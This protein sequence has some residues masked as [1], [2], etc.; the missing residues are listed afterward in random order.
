M[1]WEDWVCCPR[2]DPQSLVQCT[3][4][5]VMGVTPDEHKCAVCETLKH[6]SASLPEPT[7]ET[8]GERGPRG[9]VE[10]LYGR[11]HQVSLRMFSRIIF[12]YT[13]FAC[14]YKLTPN[15]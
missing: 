13:V 1:R 9:F 11:I 15:I 3:F 12:D 6:K 14:A 7:G 8:V 5:F 4:L 2:L 10:G